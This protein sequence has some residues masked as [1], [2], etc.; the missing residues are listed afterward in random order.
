LG[1]IKTRF[2]NLDYHGEYNY[3][4]SRLDL[5]DYHLNFFAFRVALEIKRKLRISNGIGFSSSSSSSC[6]SYS[7]SYYIFFRD[8]LNEDD[9][10]KPPFLSML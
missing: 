10:I 9:L 4:W 1:D 5:F 2:K 3:L 6:S 7:F 8:G